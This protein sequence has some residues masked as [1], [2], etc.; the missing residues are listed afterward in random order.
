MKYLIIYIL[1][2][3]KILSKDIYTDELD[4]KDAKLSDVV[5]EL[6]RKSSKTILCDLETK[7]EIIDV[8]F[9]EKTSIKKILETIKLAYNLDIIEKNGVILLKKNG[10]NR[11]ILAGKILNRDAGIRDILIKLRRNNEEYICKSGKFGEYLFENIND[12]VYYISI[13]HKLSK[14]YSYNG[15]FIKIKKGINERN[16][17]LKIDSKKNTNMLEENIQKNEKNVIIENISLKNS[18]H[19]EIKKTLNEILGSSIK[20]SSNNRNNSIILFGNSDMV[21]EVKKLIGNLDKK[22]KQVKVKAEILD[23]TENKFKD[24][25]LNLSLGNKKEDI[26]SGLSFGVLTESY[27]DGIGD[28]LGSSINFISK[29]NNEKNVLNLNLKLLESTQDLKTSAL[30]SIILLSGETGNLKMVEEVIV[31]QIKEESTENDEVNYQPIFK[32]AGIIL[33]V[34]PYVKE[35]NYI[36]LE[37]ELEA[38]DF[39]LKKTFKKDE[40]NENDGTFN[41]EGG[42]KVSRSL[43]TK[44]R[45]KH[46]DILIIGALKKEGNRKLKDKVP[47]LG[48]IPVLGNLFKN[49]SRRKENTELYIKLKAEIIEEN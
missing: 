31:G 4:I 30:P 5:A 40:E 29:F 15:E 9:K 24:I 42:S 49:D 38:S 28:I 14:G 13:D 48:D 37:I 3:I 47:F 23:I 20:I 16:I 11:N 44:I 45:I 35:D 39:K 1:L 21:L 43:K 17:F 22:V 2:V 32:E 10:I 46:N 18:H 19:L 7:D 33:K 27:I 8:F 26:D 41:S 6:S 34:T 36:Y 25:G 12:G